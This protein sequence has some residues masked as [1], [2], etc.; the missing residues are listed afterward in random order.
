MHGVLSRADNYPTILHDHIFENQSVNSG[1]LIWFLH[2]CIYVHI[3]HESKNKDKYYLFD[4]HA[5][6]NKGQASENGTS[7]L[8][9]FEKLEHLVEYF[10]CTYLD[11]EGKNLTH[12][13]LQ[14]LTCDCSM[15]KGKQVQVC[16][17]HMSSYQNEKIKEAKREKLANELSEERT[18]RLRRV[19]VYHEKISN[20]SSLERSVMAHQDAEC[21]LILFNKVI[22]GHFSQGHKKFGELAGLQCA[23]IAVYA[24]AFTDVKQISRWT[25][26]TLDSII[27]HGHKF[28]ESINKHRYLGVEDIPATVNIYGLSITVSLNF[29]VHGIL[30]RGDNHPTILHDHIFENQSV[31]SRVLIWL[32]HSCI[33]VHIKHES[34][35]KDKYYLFDSHARNDKGQASENGTSVLIKFEKLE[36]L[37]E[38]FCCT[39]LDN[40]GKNLTH[41]QLQFLTCNCSMSKGKQV[42]VCRKHMSSYQNEKIK[43]AKRQ[44][45]VD[46]MSEE[47]TARLRRLK[48]YHEK[49][50]NNS[51]LERSVKAHQDAE[52]VYIN[53]VQQSNTGTF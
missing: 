9:K 3:K 15:S 26:D 42:Q 40:E 21:V 30:S 17:K 24:A 10:C 18:A 31:N 6:N 4:S 25:S 38:Y 35:N 47:R 49:I 7:V 48:V 22:Q 52:C 19:K 20:N 36:H 27:E 39:Y 50:S 46:E 16:R 13:Q 29:N 5:R 23:V 37:I 2:S 41:Y 12:Y 51:S 11:N 53:S 45:L 43:E 8:I 34:N 44:K 1:V 28:F 33:Y 14:F 32:L